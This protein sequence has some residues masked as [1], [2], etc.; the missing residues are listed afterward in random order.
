[1]KYPNQ[2]TNPHSSSFEN[3]STNELSLAVCDVDIEY[4]ESLERVEQVIEESLDIIREKVPAIVDGPYYKGVVALGSHGVT[5]RM[6]AQCKEDEKFQTQRD[7]NRQIKLIFDAN[8][9]GIPYPQV[10]VHEP[11]QFEKK[12]VSGK[13]EQFVQ[14]QKEWSKDIGEEENT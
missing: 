14:E 10:V 3:Q 7:I 6:V 1:M 5:L 12:E 13:T 2:E 8:D 4:G 9:I 11:K